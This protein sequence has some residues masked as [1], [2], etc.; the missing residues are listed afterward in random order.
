MSQENVDF[1]RGLFEG[2]AQM[3]KEELLRAL[4]DLIRHACDP[5]VEWVEA[6]SRADARTYRGHEGVLESWR[7]WLETFD[8]YGAE[9]E[10][11]RDCGDKVLAITREEGS[12]RSSGATVSARNYVV[13]TFRDGKILRYQ[14][15]Y[16]EAAA[17]EAAGQP[18]PGA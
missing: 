10:E 1:V 13:L 15:F 3:D 4:P 2:P 12:G 14:E 5:E 11:V 7:Q 16:E 8:E 9:L 18:R 6:P 17:L